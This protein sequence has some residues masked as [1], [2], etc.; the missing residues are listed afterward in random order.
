MSVT[1]F[2]VVATFQIYFDRGALADVRFDR[3]QVLVV[4]A[5]VLFN[6][7]FDYFT[8]IQTKIFIEASISAKSIFRSLI[9]IGSDLLV[10]MNT[11]IL[12]YAIF[13]LI[14]IQYFVWPSAELMF[15]RAKKAESNV[16]AVEELPNHLS[17]FVSSEAMKRLA[18]SDNFEGI[19]LPDTE[20]TDEYQTVSVYYHSTIDPRENDLQLLILSTISRLDVS[21]HGGFEDVPDGRA[22]ELART[23]HSKTGLNRWVRDAEPPEDDQLPNVEQAL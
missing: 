4:A 3:L 13:V 15:V 20:V 11:F 19:L 6:I 22:V 8:I 21:A 9:F 5:F 23:L 17:E 10:T 12:S 14:V 1:S 2:T 18:F 7:C 16:A